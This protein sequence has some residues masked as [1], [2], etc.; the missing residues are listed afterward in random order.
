MNFRPAVIACLT[1]L[2]QTAF[3]SGFAGN[4]FRVLT[5]LLTDLHCRKLTN[6][7][8]GEILLNRFLKNSLIFYFRGN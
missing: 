1:T 2:V 3:Q 7:A 5:S 6:L 4:F 8:G